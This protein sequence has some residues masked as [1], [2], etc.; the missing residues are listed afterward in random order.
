MEKK[1]ETKKVV[2][3]KSKRVLK[4]E[5]KGKVITDLSGN[6]IKPNKNMYVEKKNKFKE[7]I[8]K[9]K[10]TYRMIIIA[11]IALILIISVYIGIQSIILNKKYGKYEKIM[12]N[13]GFSELYTNKEAKAGE[14]V[15]RIEMLKIVIAS[16]YNITEVESKGFIAQGEYNGDEWANLA[17]AFGIID[18]DYITK[19]NYDEPASELEAI[20]TYINAR[21]KILNIPITSE[22]ESKFKNLQSYTEEERKYIN[23]AAQNGLIENT[24]KTV[25]L[26]KKLIKGKFNKIVITFINTYNTIAPKGETLVLKEES[27]PSNAS[28]YPYILYSVDKEVYEYEP[29]YGAE[30]DYQTPVQTYK[31]RKDYYSQVEYRSELLYDT[32]LNVDYKTIDKD[33]FFN[34]LNEFLRYNYSEEIKSYVDYVKKNKIVIEGKSEVQF[35]IF[36]LDGIRYRA[37]IKLTFEIKNSDTD[38]NL[39]LGD[40]LNEEEITYKNKKYEVYIDLPMGSTL[41]SNSMFVDL[42]PVI[43]MMVND[44]EASN[45]NEF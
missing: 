21:D 13:Y 40:A 11:V 42:E 35:P 33:K 23:D 4:K 2:N 17:K 41:F 24:N 6:V 30:P 8:R 10:K 37:R 19:D 20:K 15:T 29:I 26:N 36:Y 25:K 44:K 7:H 31:Y 22:K 28:I 45:L 39:L 32:I 34:T 38:K 16:T 12:D 5:K 18:K 14:R 43:Q 3:N 1:K 27:K 9:N